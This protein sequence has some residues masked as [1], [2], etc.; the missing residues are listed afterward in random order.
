MKDELK[1][2]TEMD[3]YVWLNYRTL[4][5]KEEYFNI[6]EYGNRSGEV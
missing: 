1:R 6:L 5:P 3:A 4:W 2:D